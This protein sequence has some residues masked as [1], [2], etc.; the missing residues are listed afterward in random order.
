MLVPA[1]PSEIITSLG[2]IWRLQNPGIKKFTWGTRNPFKRA[3]LDYF[4]ISEN[5]LSL[6]QVA[7]ILPSYR[8]DHSIIT[9]SLNISN[10][11]RGKGSWKLNNKLLENKELVKLVMDAILLIK[12]IYALP[13]YSSKF[14][15]NSDDEHLELLI[16]DSLFLDTLLCQVR[17]LIISFSKNLAKNTWN[18]EKKNLKK[19]LRFW[20]RW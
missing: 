2:H 16:S 19:I 14:I 3:R 10:Q 17:G 4:L 6:C 11:E 20:R 18:Q 15:K 8:C 13:V 1:Q 12:Q 5:L 9:L 7:K